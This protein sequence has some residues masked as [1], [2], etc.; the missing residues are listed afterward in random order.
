MTLTVRPWA[1]SINV[2]SACVIEAGS[3][4][5]AGH[6][7]GRNTALWTG[8]PGQLH[9]MAS[10]TGHHPV[11]WYDGFT[12]GHNA[13]LAEIRAASPDGLALGY[14]DGTPGL[15]GHREP[16]VRTFG[17]MPDNYVPAAA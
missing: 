16:Y 9:V 5:Q 8:L 7:A 15:L 1:S 13:V 4:Y 10:L 3:D 14:S 6:A 11:A 12:A 17:P 2:M